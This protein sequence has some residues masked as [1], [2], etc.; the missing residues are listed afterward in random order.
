MTANPI[1]TLPDHHSP[2]ASNASN[3]A[4]TTNQTIDG[5]CLRGTAPIVVMDELLPDPYF[6]GYAIFVVTMLPLK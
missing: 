1:G 6:F 3:V 4:P 5:G 2:P